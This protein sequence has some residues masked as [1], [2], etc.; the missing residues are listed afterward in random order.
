MGIFCG[1]LTLYIEYKKERRIPMQLYTHTLPS[2]AKLTGYLRDETNEMP[3]FNIRPARLILPGGGMPFAARGR[4]TP[5]AMRFAG[6]LPDLCAGIHLCPHAG[7]GPARWQPLIDAAGAILHLRRNAAKLRLDPFKIAVCGF[8]A[9]GHLAAPT[10][11][12]WDAAPVQKALG[13]TGRGSPP[14]RCCAGLPGHYVGHQDPRRVH[15]Q[16]GRG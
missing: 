11:I 2:G 13:I 9:G 7:A 4:Q 6:G 10:A 8:S 12:L 14:R 1:M 3:A 5:S 15:R 16:P